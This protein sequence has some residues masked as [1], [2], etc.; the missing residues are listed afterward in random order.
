MSRQTWKRAE[1]RVADFFQ[2]RRRPLSG[3]NH[4]TGRGDDCQHESLYIEAKHGVSA[5]L[6]QAAALFRHTKKKQEKE[7][8]EMTP[9]IALCPKSME[10]FLLVVHS[11][12]L[13]VLSLEYLT[14]LGYRIESP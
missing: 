5:M 7:A 1:K 6:T 2:T 14:Q 11:S 10:G 4:G 13:E 12:D 9:I 8:P 3:L